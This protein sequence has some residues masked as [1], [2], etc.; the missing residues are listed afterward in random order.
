[1]GERTEAESEKFADGPYA[2]V[3][4]DMPEANGLHHFK[5]KSSKVKVNLGHGNLK[6]S[7][8]CFTIY[9]QSRYVSNSRNVHLL[10]LQACIAN[11]IKN[12]P[13]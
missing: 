9:Q 5:R 4:S 2:S 8:L 1:M 7:F 11:K 12:Q 13:K 6:F 3:Q 10:M